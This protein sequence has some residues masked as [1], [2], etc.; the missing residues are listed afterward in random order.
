MLLVADM[1][2]VV[3]VFDFVEKIGSLIIEDMWSYE[4]MGMCISVAIV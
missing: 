1:Q 3:A 2:F 4:L